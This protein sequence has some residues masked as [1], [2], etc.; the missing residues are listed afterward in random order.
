MLAE[1]VDGLGCIGRKPVLDLVKRCRLQGTCRR[2]HRNIC[3]RQTAAFPQQRL[4]LEVLEA[5]AAVPCRQGDGQ[6]GSRERGQVA[7]LT[8]LEY[9][10]GAGLVLSKHPWTWRRRGWRP[11]RSCHHVDHRIAA[12][13]HFQHFAVVVRGHA[14]WRLDGLHCG[15]MGKLPDDRLPPTHRLRTR[16]RGLGR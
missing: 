4:A 5:Q 9:R 12:D 14:R 10:S 15:E 6:A 8:E 13:R 1:P 3:A 7:G 11:R 2:L 16:P